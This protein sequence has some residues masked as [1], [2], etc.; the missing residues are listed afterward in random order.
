[1]SNEY[2]ISTNMVSV[3]SVT[4][5]SLSFLLLLLVMSLAAKADES[6]W[7]LIHSDHSDDEAGI[8]FYIDTKILFY[9]SEENLRV[10]TREI[11]TDFSNESLKDINCPDYMYRNIGCTKYSENK[12]PL[13]PCY[14]E[15]TPNE[16]I[17]IEPESLEE[18]LHDAICVDVESP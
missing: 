3:K 10:W 11:Y 7:K 12:E 8:S 6:R 17:D 9:I 16:W 5:V 14:S 13:G 2:I 4:I 15:D 18:K 1:M